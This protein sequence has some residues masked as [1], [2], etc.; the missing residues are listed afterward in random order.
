MFAIGSGSSRAGSKE[1][2]IKLTPDFSMPNGVLHLFLNGNKV[3]ELEI[4]K[5]DGGYIIT[6]LNGSITDE[7]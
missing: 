2:Q 3:D 6:S 4:K 7:D 1:G 5:M